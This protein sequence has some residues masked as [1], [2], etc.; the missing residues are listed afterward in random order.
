MVDGESALEG[1]VVLERGAL[2]M[3]VRVPRRDVEVVEDLRLLDEIRWRPVVGRKLVE[4]AG[5]DVAPG[6][7]TEMEVEGFDR[8]LGR[9]LSGKARP[10]VAIRPRRVD[11]VVEIAFGLPEPVSRPVRHRSS[12]HPRSR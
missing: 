4:E 2:G 5:D 12:R 7:L 8:L 3:A 9:L 10:L 11:G 6:L 1:P